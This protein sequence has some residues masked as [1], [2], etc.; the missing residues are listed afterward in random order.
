MYTKTA[1]NCTEI[2]SGVNGGAAAV[3]DP[4]DIDRAHLV[5]YVLRQLLHKVVTNIGAISLL[6]ALEVRTQSLKIDPHWN[7]HI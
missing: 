6:R 4:E 7:R 1:A 3:H 5:A 2:R